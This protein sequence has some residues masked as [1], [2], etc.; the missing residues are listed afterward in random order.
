MLI[1]RRIEHNRLPKTKAS[2]LIWLAL[3]SLPFWFS[4]DLAGI[5]FVFL[6]EPSGPKVKTNPDTLRTSNTIAC[7]KQKR[8]F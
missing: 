6:V 5:N 2:F 4:G 7:Q 3:C 8:A 1:S